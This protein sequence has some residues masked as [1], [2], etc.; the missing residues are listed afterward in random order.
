MHTILITGGTGCIGSVT[1]Y[2][3]L[4]TDKVGKIVV[5]SRSRNYDTLK[6]WLGEKMDPGQWRA[7]VT[8]PGFELY[9]H[10]SAITLKSGFDLLEWYRHG[11]IVFVHGAVD[12]QSVSSPAGG[13]QL[14]GLPFFKRNAAAEW[15]DFDYDPIW[16]QGYTGTLTNGSNWLDGRQ[17]P[18]AK[19][20]QLRDKGVH[21]LAPHVIANT[22]FVFGFWYI[23]DDA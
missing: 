20:M 5:A 4:Q 10:P 15:A 17:S 1:I 12:V 8:A 6:L 18:G 9:V 16:I 7:T 3:L 2:K 13:V 14:N 19:A 11:K 21:D 23:T 22:N